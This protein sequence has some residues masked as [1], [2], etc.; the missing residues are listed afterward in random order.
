MLLFEVLK[1]IPKWQIFLSYTWTL[2]IPNLSC[3]WS[4]K[5]I[6]TLAAFWDFNGIQV[7]RR[8]KLLFCKQHF[9]SFQSRC[10]Q[11][12]FFLEVQDLKDNKFNNQWIYCFA[13]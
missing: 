4:L 11:S 10:L 12:L 7:S 13:Y 1:L 8:N 5:P 3:T 2:E 9:S 6:H